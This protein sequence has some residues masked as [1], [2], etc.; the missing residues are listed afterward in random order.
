MKGP[1][2]EELHSPDDTP[3][4]GAMIL[5]TIFAL[6]LVEVCSQSRLSEQLEPDSKTVP[7]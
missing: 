4:L 3:V 6:Q 5:F 2:R 1:T 7:H